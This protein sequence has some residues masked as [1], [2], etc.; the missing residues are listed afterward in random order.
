MKLGP[1]NTEWSIDTSFPKATKIAVLFSG[2]IDSTLIA[3]IA[4]DLYGKDN[5]FLLWSDSMF[6]EDNTIMKQTI[7]FNVNIVAKHLDLLP[8][9][10]PVD[11]EHF[12]VDPLLAQRNSWMDAQSKLGFDHMAMGMTAMFWDIMSLQSLTRKEIIN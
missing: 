10:A 3:S 2:G 7:K 4:I 8:Y 11:Y 5:V 1:N 12:K 6:C 9:Y